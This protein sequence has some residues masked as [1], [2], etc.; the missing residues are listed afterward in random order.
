MFS[1]LSFEPAWPID[2]WGRL[3]LV[4]GLAVRDAVSALYGIVVGLRWPNDL[5]LDAGKTGGI[6]AEASDGRI[7][8]GCGI[9][10]MWSDP[11]PGAAA[12]VDDEAAAGQPL[13]LATAWVD[14]FLA[15][16]SR[17]PDDWGIEDYRKACVTIGRRVSYAAG[18]G[19]A[20]SIDDDGALIVETATGR[21]TVTSGEVRL[22][23]PATLPIDPG[24]T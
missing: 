8:V 18:T 7:V 13:D 17:P 12:L 11:M 4:A 24:G 1:S 9:N 20:V 16:E 10:L 2:A 19:T 6:L 14:R 5:V 22:H 21:V 3:S 23:V 15:R